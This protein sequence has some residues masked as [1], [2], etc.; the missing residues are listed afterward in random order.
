[1]SNAYVNTILF[2][3]SKQDVNDEYI[4]GLMPYML[5]GEWIHK[6]EQDG[7]KLEEQLSS[8]PLCDSDNSFA[9]KEITQKESTIHNSTKQ[10]AAPSVVSLQH[11][12]QNHSIPTLSAS[13]LPLSQPD[14]IFA[15]KR[16][17][18]N[19][20]SLFWAIY[21]VEHPEDAFLGTRANAEVEHRLKVVAELKKTPKRL[22]ETNSKL[23]IEQTQALLGSMMVA[24]EDKLEFCVA[25]SA[26]YN[27]P[28]IV[29]YPK[30]YRVFSPMV[31]VDLQNEDAI[32]LYAET[33]SQEKGKHMVY[34]SEKNPSSKIICDIMDQKTMGPL[35]SMSNYKNPELDAI[36]SKL[37]ISVSST[38][39]A[40][41]EKRRKK[42]DIYND[43]KVL[44]H[45][46]QT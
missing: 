10:C 6:F 29:V 46:D 11:R 28:I 42:E 38:T 35:K 37:G 19:H 32:I 34:N 17:Y 31:D 7:L 13:R 12:L 43:I 1:M 18:N 9:E 30:T 2:G 3:V 21:E 33:P 5:T 41:K 45:N 4:K 15:A 22:K 40:G 8:L 44:I 26:Y 24:K 20:N 36:A 16:K 23:T 27:K 25:Y 14:N 39:E